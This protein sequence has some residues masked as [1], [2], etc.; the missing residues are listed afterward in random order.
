MKLRD[1]D[2]KRYSKHYKILF[3]VIVTELLIVSIVC[4]SLLINWFSTPEESH[5]LLNIAGVVIAALIVT[6]A[7]YHFKDHPF[8]NE[9]AYVWNLK[10]Q[11]NQI[12]RKQHKI[13]PLM[14]NNNVDAMIIMNYMYKGSK[15]LYELDDNTITLDSLASRSRLLDIRL[16]EQNLTVSTD[17]YHPDLLGQF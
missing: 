3:A 6:Y 12:V 15:Q 5:F 13:E 4:S 2:K 10:K 17:D 8:M 14:E 16:A 1:I 11:L 7:L 9:V